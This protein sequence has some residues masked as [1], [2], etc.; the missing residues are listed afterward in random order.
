VHDLP[1]DDLA[2]PEATRQLVARWLHDPRFAD[3]REGLPELVQAALRDDREAIAELEDAF[4]GPLPIGTGGRRGKVG[5]GT[6]RINQVVLRETA[7]GL[8]MAMRAEGVPAKVAVV[9]DTRRDSRRFARV[10][11]EQ[12]ASLDL[13]VLLIDAPRPT[14]LLSYI[15]RQRGCGAGVVLSASHNPASDNGIKIYDHEGA[16][17]LGDRDRALMRA[18]TEAM[19]AP[20]PPID[21]AKL[22][23]IE[24]VATP[25]SLAR[26]DDA[27]I[28]YVLEQGVAPADLSHVGLAVA[29]TPLHGVGHTCTVPVL[30]RKGIRVHLV[31]GQLPDGGRF[32]TVASANPEDP[33]AMDMARA[34]AEARGADLVIA[35]D[36]D[37]DRLGAL[38][39][40]AQGRFE[41]VDGN[42]LGVLMLDHV[43]RHA[44]LPPRGWVLTTVV[45]T[46]LI[47]TLARA[48]GVEV[49]EDLLVGFKHHAGMMAEA[50]ERPVV[51]ATEES[52]GY[53]RGNEVHDKDG[54]IAALLLAEAAALAKAEGRTLLDDLERIFARHGYHR[55]KTANIYAY[56]AAGRE[57]I[58]KLVETWRERPP[59]SFGGLPVVSREDRSKPRTTGSTTRD[60]PGNVLVHQLK[61][62]AGV[63]RLVLRPSGTE[64][65]VKVYAL[66][67]GPGGL[68]EAALA[69]QRETLDR[70]AD[71]V[72]ADARAQAAAVM[73][74]WLGTRTEA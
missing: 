48:H 1:V 56:G 65:K 38:V 73:A 2:L 39:R 11:A 63:F 36:P 58:A 43:L 37:A 45:T 10:V 62:E 7:H 9:Y 74:P 13:D 70:L 69:R 4:D 25:E 14:P 66:V 29:Y 55:E 72:L 40:N 50:P 16:Q 21:P 52:H 17:V 59:E 42:R 47:G 3:D 27:Y 31:E 64:P 71:E 22:H 68:D 67:H 57:A 23:R 34:L 53:V 46:A 51:F 60:L 20:L 6:N 49:V 8:A 30:E 26:V 19:G 61:M 18:I 54:A 32:G 24:T 5:A 28:G 15:V 35:A 12:L 41:V 33:A 44:T